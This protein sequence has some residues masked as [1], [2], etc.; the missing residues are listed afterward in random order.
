MLHFEGAIKDYIREHLQ[1]DKAMP[2][3]E[4]SV[5][6]NQ[7]LNDTPRTLRN[8][9]SF[10]WDRREDSLASEITFVIENTDGTKSPH[11]LPDKFPHLDLER[12]GYQYALYPENKVEAWVGYGDERL[13]VFT[14][15]IDKVKIS[16]DNSE[17]EVTAR[18]NMKYLLDQ[19]IIPDDAKEL[20]Y[21]YDPDAPLL[22][23]ALIADLINKAGL[24]AEVEESKFEDDSAYTITSDLSFELGLKYIDAIKQLTDSIGYKIYATNIG[25]IRAERNIY[26]SGT[27]EPVVVFKDYLNLSSGDFVIDTQDAR[28]TLIIA[29]DTGWE[30]FENKQFADWLRPTFPRAAKITIPWANTPQKR[31]LAAQSAFAMM[32]RVTRRIS[33]VAVAHP[34]LQIGDVARL[35]ERVSTAS[36]IYRITAIKTE[37]SDGTFFDTIELEAFVNADNIVAKST[38]RYFGQA[39]AT[40]KTKDVWLQPRESYNIVLDMRGI[41]NEARISIHS[42]LD[43]DVIGAIINMLKVD[44]SGW[45]ITS[46]FSYDDILE[47]ANP[48]GLADSTELNKK[49]IPTYEAGLA[50]K[51]TIQEVYGGSILYLSSA[52]PVPV[53]SSFIALIKC[54][55]QTKL[56]PSDQIRLTLLNI[57]GYAD[58][59]PSNQTIGWEIKSICF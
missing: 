46:D 13:H 17:L 4:I 14:G 50:L 16:A 40:W 51:N 44:G 6:N 7:V 26:P 24:I 1:V 53:N 22:I 59:S 47:Q 49:G 8:V 34:A 3:I 28:D 27:A 52:D 30:E 56:F 55:T 48:E 58:L 15:V 18:D 38:G 5:W 54:T 43:D 20:T 33:I 19:Q 35:S 11:Y 41:F 23:S 42:S 39:T 29:S 31:K 37:L 21:E 12:S 32:L 10:G 25:T 45:S 57:T 9:K 36:D 2:T